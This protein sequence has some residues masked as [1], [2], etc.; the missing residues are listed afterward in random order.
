MSVETFAKIVGET[1]PELM[2][3]MRSLLLMI[4][5]QLIGGRFLCVRCD[6]FE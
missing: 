3:F 2:S 6:S 1:D 4:P 5:G